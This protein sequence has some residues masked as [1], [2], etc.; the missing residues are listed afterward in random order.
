MTSVLE[1]DDAAA[2]RLEAMYT[3]RDVVAQRREVLRALALQTGENVLDV[4]VGPGFLAQEMAHIVGSTGSVSGIDISQSM[5]ALARSRILASSHAHSIDLDEADAT[6]LP[7]PDATFDAAVATQVY[8]Y[9]AD[10]SAALSE[11]YRV[12]RPGGRALILDTDW[13]SIV[14]NAADP[15]LA[16]QILKAWDE[17]ATDSHLPRTLST[18]LGSAGFRL[19]RREVLV[20]FNPENDPDTYSFRVRDLIAGFVVGRQGIRT[21]DVESW[22]EGLQ[23][24]GAEGRYF[25]SLNRYLFLAVK[26]DAI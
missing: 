13:D 10:V 9:V 3:T 19:A 7:F 4:G 14:W 5:L 24:L 16:D 26:P 17:H 12:L 25:F 1:F 15:V 18:H 8:E 6:A 21:D 20:L 23:R 22:L 11:L 2:R